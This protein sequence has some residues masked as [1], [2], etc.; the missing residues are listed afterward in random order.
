MAFGRGFC[1]DEA[2]GGSFF[3]LA[4]GVG[5]FLGNQ[6]FAS[7]GQF[8][9]ARHF[10][11]GNGPFALDG[12]SPAFVHRPVRFGLEPFADGSLQCTFDVGF[13][14][15]CQHL[16]AEDFDTSGEEPGVGAERFA[17]DCA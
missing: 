12:D 15:D 16:H 4:P 1:L 5:A 9:L 11:L 10:V 13:R 3:C 17:Q 14:P 6:V 2:C 8:D 7:G